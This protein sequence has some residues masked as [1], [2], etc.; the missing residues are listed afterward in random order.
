MLDIKGH[1]SGRATTTTNPIIA[2][3]FELEKGTLT[4]KKTA[5]KAENIA[6]KGSLNNGTS[7][8]KKTTVFK[9]DT[10]R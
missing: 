10:A 8:S 1:I 4:H 3:S 5:L 2:L 6:F 9:I 7:R